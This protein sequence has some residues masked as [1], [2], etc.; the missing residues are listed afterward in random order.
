MFFCQ[1][2]FRSNRNFAK[3]SK[4]LVKIENVGR[5]KNYGKKIGKNENFDHNR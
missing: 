4:F 1:S 5:N 2:N 3:K